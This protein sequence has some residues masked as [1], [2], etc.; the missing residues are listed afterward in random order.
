MSNFSNAAKDGI[1]AS[2]NVAVPGA[3]SGS[4]R[5]DRVGGF[6]P[7]ASSE[8]HDVAGSDRVECFRRE[9]Q[10]HTGLAG[11]RH[12]ASATGYDH[13][14]HESGGSVT[15]E[16]RP[17]AHNPRR[18]AADRAN[19]RLGQSERRCSTTTDPKCCGPPTTET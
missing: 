13:A 8:N 18:R 7:R 1:E 4:S 19:S 9:G 2:K 6:E 10:L 14:T 11:Q 12:R 3:R 16:N 15:V 5:G 17:L